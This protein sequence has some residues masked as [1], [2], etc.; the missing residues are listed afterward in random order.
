[1][2]I[3]VITI[4]LATFNSC[5]KEEKKKPSNAET[6][7]VKKSEK[8]I[9]ER[10]LRIDGNVDTL[11]SYEL[12]NHLFGKFFRQRAEFY[13]IENPN[14]TLYN[15]PVKSITLYFL[16]GMLAKT[17]FELEND[18]SDDLIKSYGAFTIKGYDTLTRKLLKTEKVVEARDDKNVLNKNLIN[19]QL[20]WDRDTKFIYARVD[21][22]KLQKRFEYI[23]SIKYYQEKYQQAEVP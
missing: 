10:F 15:H 11:R 7:E 17:K 20:K 13:V 6:Q 12:A 23:E 16:D 8:N 2:K 19:Y 3:I 4:L 1:M 5:E 9:P 14:K 22:S 21:K 18:I